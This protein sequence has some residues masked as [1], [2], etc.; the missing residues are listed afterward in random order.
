MILELDGRNEHELLFPLWIEKG[1][2]PLWAQ[3]MS[4]LVASECNWIDYIYHSF[5]HPLAQMW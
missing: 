4:H 5:F 2:Y 1:I 3:L